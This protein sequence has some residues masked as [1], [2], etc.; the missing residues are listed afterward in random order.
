L[1]FGLELLYAFQVVE[2]CCLGVF[3]GEEWVVGGGVK[4]DEV[5]SVEGE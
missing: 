4:E 1:D 3:L 2:C 5:E